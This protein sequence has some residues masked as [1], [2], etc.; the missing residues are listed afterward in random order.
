[1]NEQW[2]SLDQATEITGASEAIILDTIKKYQDNPSAIKTKS[3][4]DILYLD[5]AQLVCLFPSSANP[6]EKEKIPGT[7]FKWFD[8]LRRAY[9]VSMNTMFKRV[10]KVKDQHIQ[11][12]QAQYEKRLAELSN[13]HISETKALGRHIAKLEN[14]SLF[15][16]NQIVAQQQTISQL[17][18]RYDA[19][20]LALRNKNDEHLTQTFEKDITP[21]NS[22]IEEAQ[23]ANQ[24]SSKNT[25]EITAD[26]I[27]QHAYLMRSKKEFEK[28]AK[29]L[30]RAALLGHC[31][32]MGALG[33]SYFIGEGVE[34]NQEQAIAWLHVASEYGFSPADKKLDLMQIKFPEQYSKGL[35]LAENFALQIKLNLHKQGNAAA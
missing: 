6:V 11:D 18:N 17:N 28:A 10:E 2:I 35:K 16:Q 31:Q 1:M 7:V 3:E 4:D 14:D 33:R 26:Q 25:Q 23:Q 8:E 5:K 30:T 9:E 12:M 19:V 21:D 34:A 22:Q 13:A 20:V 27:V 29:L 15:Y 32:A 24:E